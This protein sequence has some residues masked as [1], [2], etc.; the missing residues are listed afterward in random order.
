MSDLRTY[1]ETNP[2]RL[3]HKWLHYFEIYERHLQRFRGADITIVEFGVSHGGS[4]QM[5]KHY[6]GARASVIGVDIDPR[7]KVVEEERIKVVIG[8]QADRAFLARLRSIVPRVDVLIDD[9]GHS[10]EQQITTFEEMFPHI[11]PDGVYV[12]EDLHTSYW[13]AYGGGLRRQGTFIEYSKHL[14]DQL[15]AWYWRRET[16]VNRLRTRVLGWRPAPEPAAGSRGPVPAF[17]RS[18]YALHFYDSVLVIEKRLISSPERRMTGQRSW[19]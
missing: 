16:L 18:A 11:S 19:G 2:G 12:A 5:W 15:H 14:I 1:F 3:I 7:C 10:M 13:P 4:L 9:G 8:D 6:F 17:T